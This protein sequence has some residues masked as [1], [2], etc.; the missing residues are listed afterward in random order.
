MISAMDKFCLVVRSGSAEGLSSS[1]PRCWPKLFR[2][3]ELQDHLGIIVVLPVSSSFR[4]FK[5]RC[6]VNNEVITVFQVQLIGGNT[7][8]MIQWRRFSFHVEIRWSSVDTENI[9]MD[10]V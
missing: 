5:R 7:D 2:V 8:E 3:S 6:R 4:I 1:F 10:K 9:I